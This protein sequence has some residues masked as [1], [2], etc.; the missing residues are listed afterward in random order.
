[1]PKNRIDIMHIDEAPWV[2]EVEPQEGPR[3]LG[4]QVVGDL[5]KGLRAMIIALAPN[6][7]GNLHSHSQDEIIHVLE[8]GVTIGNRK[9]GPGH[10]MY[11]KGG[12]QYKFDTGPEGVRFMNIRPGPSN[13]HVVGKEPVDENWKV[14]KVSS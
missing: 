4:A 2:R 10:V 3:K 1:M 6:R 7:P 14:G 12:S 8:G 13:Y 11:I 5:D 9:L